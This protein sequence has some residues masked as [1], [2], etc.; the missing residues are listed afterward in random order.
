MITKSNFIVGHGCQRCFWFKYKGYEDPDLN[1]EQAQQRLKD[2][3]EVG[4]QVKE[5]FAKGVEIPF[6]GRDYEEM[7]RLTLQAMDNGSKVIFEGSFLIDGVFIRVDIMEKSSNGWNIY[8]V[9]SSSKPKP[10]HKE[11]A[12]IQWHVLNQVE[13]LELRDMYVITLDKDYER[14]E[15]LKLKNVFKRHLLTEYVESNQAETSKTLL[16]LKKIAELESPP[17]KRI[18]GNPDVKN[19][20]TFK[21]HCWPKDI[22]NINSV[23]K[24]RGMHTKDK[25]KLYDEGIDI[26]EKIQDIKSFSKI[27]QIQIESTLKNITFINKEIIERF[28]SKVSYQI[29]FL[30][31]ET[32]NETIPSHNGQKPNEKVPFQYSLHIQKTPND[33][34]D[35]DDSHYEFLAN[36]ED[37]PRQMIAESMLNNI[38]QNGSIITYHKSFEIGVIK[39]LARSCPDLSSKLLDL[40]NRIL[41]LKD[42]FSKGGY[43]HPE[44][45]GSFSIKKVL[46]ALCKDNK[47]LDYKKLKI[48][49]GGMAST[50]FRELKNK[51]D[52]EINEI[53]KDLLKY[54]WLD[55]YAMHAIYEKLLTIIN[56]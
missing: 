51:T 55:T 31:F 44:F 32:Y 26:F 14:G 53:R 15:K 8:E 38:P 16:N 19:E 9:K 25:F 12:S 6:L 28:I 56:N 39:G 48:S 22:D 4:D 33:S 41:D 2:G 17:E 18:S 13:D 5:T 10:I 40:N 29:S 42:P 20:C 11:D 3:E 46:P 7:H 37:D 30:D 45:G 21:A 24:I 52:D 47:E 49:N 34:V 23:F 36:C 1:D 54:C 27:R 43:Y 50:V 35:A